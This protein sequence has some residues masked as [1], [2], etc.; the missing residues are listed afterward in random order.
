MA[1]RDITIVM[2]FIK[3]SKKDFVIIAIYVDDLNIVGTIKAFTDAAERLKIE[4][5]MKDLGPTSFCLGL[6]LIKVPGDAYES[7]NIHSEVTSEI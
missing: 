5:E 7:E 6:Q 1:W 4:F 3:R 2:V